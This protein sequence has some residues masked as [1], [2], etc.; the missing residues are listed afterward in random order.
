MAYFYTYVDPD[1]LDKMHMAD[2]VREEEDPDD[3][4]KKTNDIQMNK[5]KMTKL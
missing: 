1:Q 2:S 4:K 5:T 3:T